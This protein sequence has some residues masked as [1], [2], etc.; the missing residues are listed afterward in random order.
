MGGEGI[1]KCGGG[2]VKCVD[3][4]RLLGSVQ[5]EARKADCLTS[6]DSNIDR[7]LEV[8]LPW[9]KEPVRN[10]IIV[11]YANTANLLPCFGIPS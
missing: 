9:C 10:S 3:N 7:R 2:Y 11:L 5:L 6:L 4:L 1:G 8:L